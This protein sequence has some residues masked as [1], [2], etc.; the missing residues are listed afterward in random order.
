MSESH[1]DVRR[2]ERYDSTTREYLLA[3]ITD[4]DHASQVG[5][6]PNRLAIDP[7]P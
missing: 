4:E 7:A 5:Q 3:I 2:L 6:R 1:F